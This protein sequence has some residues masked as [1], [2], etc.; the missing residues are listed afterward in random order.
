[1]FSVVV[2]EALSLAAPQVTAASLCKETG[3][4]RFLLP[5]FTR[6]LPIKLFS[7]LEFDLIDFS[8][9]DW[10]T[11][12][13]GRGFWPRGAD[14]SRLCN[15]QWKKKTHKKNASYSQSREKTPYYWSESRAGGSANLKALTS[16]EHQLTSHAEC[17]FL[18]KTLQVLLHL[19]WKIRTWP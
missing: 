14:Q 7:F 11:C 5:W 19:L 13:P 9:C 17:A 15:H 18:K 1:M 6:C 4:R 12:D 16:A 3:R 8:I 2:S 10:G